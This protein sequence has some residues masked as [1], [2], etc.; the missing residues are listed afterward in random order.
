MKE[1]TKVIL[2]RGSEDEYF[3]VHIYVVEE[4]NDGN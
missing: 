3:T 4:D 2:T 1:N